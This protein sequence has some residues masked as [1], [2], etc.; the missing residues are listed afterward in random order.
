MFSPSWPEWAF[1]II[2]FFFFVY[3]VLDG[4]DLGIGCLVPFLRD[5]RE[6]DRL[7]ALIAPVWDGNELWLV[8]GVGYLF[9][10]FP[11]AYAALLSVFYLPFTA[12]IVAFMVRA[13][14][15][16][17][18]YHDD[19]SRLRLWR[20]LFGAGSAVAAFSVLTVLGLLLWGLPFSGPG[21]VS[22]HVADVALAF[23]LAFGLAG[24]LLLIW[25]GLVYA[26]SRQ[27]SDSLTRLARRLWPAVM[28]ASVVVGCLG[29]THREF[30]ASKPVVWI[31]GILYLTALITSR[32]LLGR[33]PRAF[34]ASC[35]ALAGLWLAAGA[36]L[37]PNVLRAANR[38]DWSLSLAQAAAPVSTLRPLTVV[39]LALIPAVAGCTI[40]M[41]KT[42]RRPAAGE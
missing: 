13:A 36:T 31:G 32:A 6:A 22:R 38:M 42:L 23:P 4:F 1:A 19:P 40:L 29:G 25:H 9:A 39:T 30:A 28:G 33:G 18:S 27:T 17:F 21:V 5:P 41:Y 37:M 8:M 35:A 16:E 24:V 2:L 12:V 3:T 34:R 14:A 26:L 20:R 11:G 7:V 10:A 15:L